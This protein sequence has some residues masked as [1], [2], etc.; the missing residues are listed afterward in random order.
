MYPACLPPVNF[1]SDRE[2]FTT[3]TRQEEGTICIISGWGATEGKGDN[4]TLQSATVP[5]MK[6]SQCNQLLGEGALPDDRYLCAGYL[7]GGID[8]C[9]VSSILILD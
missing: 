8:T 9:Q 2:V 3:S 7:S 4:S 1:R 6:N 5:I